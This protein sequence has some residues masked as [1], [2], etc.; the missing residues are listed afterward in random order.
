MGREKIIFPPFYYYPQTFKNLSDLR[1]ST[2][3]HFKTKLYPLFS[4]PQGI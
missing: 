3:N 4:I 2:V 1:G